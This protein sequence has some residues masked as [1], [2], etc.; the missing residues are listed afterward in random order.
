[1]ERDLR[2]TDMKGLS[3]PRSV[4]ISTNAKYQIRYM[5]CLCKDKTSLLLLI[6]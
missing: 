6:K 3:I 2:V 1:M 4:K 5:C